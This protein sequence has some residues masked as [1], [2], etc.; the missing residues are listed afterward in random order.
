MTNDPA[1]DAS[2]REFMRAL[3]T[4]DKPLGRY[5]ELGVTALARHLGLSEDQLGGHWCS[6]CQGIWYGTMLEAECPICANR[7]G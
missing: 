6:H 5:R 3:V 2:S 4:P 7:H 1:D